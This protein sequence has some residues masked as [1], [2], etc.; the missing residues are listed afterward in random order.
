LKQI[1]DCIL[2]RIRNP[3]TGWQGIDYQ[4][5]DSRKNGTWTRTFYEY[6]SVGDSKTLKVQKN[7]EKSHTFYEKKYMTL[8]TNL[9]ATVTVT[10]CAI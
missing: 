5:E 10:C 3:K 4:V 8:F 9:G 1:T 2:M 7:Y 6:S